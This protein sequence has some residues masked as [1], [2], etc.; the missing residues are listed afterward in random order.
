[1]QVGIERGEPMWG[2]E[3][4]LQI[5]GDE[6][7]IVL[8]DVWMPDRELAIHPR[9]RRPGLDGGIAPRLQRLPPHEE[10]ARLRVKQRVIVWRKP[11]QQA[12]APSHA[13]S[14]GLEGIQHMP[15]LVQ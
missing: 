15:Q 12:T 1:M 10:P 7:P 9:S 11:R 5:P 13:A 6:L 2:A 14:R 4:E 3:E 8:E